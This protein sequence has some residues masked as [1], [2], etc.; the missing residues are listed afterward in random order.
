MCT[1]PT[2]ISNWAL[3]L[4]RLPTRL[5]SII[6]LLFYTTPHY[7]AC[8]HYTTLCCL[9]TL[10]HT[11]P[12]Y[13]TLCT[14]RHTTTHYVHYTPQYAHYATLCTLRHTMHTTTHY[15]HYHTLCTLPH[16][17][18]TTTHYALYHTLCTLL[19][20]SLV[21]WRAWWWQLCAWHK[22]GHT[23]KTSSGGVQNSFHRLLHQQ[24]VA[25]VLNW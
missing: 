17:M 25:I 9:C 3:S 14:L 6:L 11:I 24:R 2:T 4:C 20:S 22:I 1:K 13:H 7:A 12:H 18:H 21:T 23:G 19:H 10:H 5:T 15:A 8:A 16:T